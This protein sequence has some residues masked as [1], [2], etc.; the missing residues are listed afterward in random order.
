MKSFRLCVGNSGRTS[1]IMEVLLIRMIGAKSRTGS[2]CSFLNRL[3][4]AARVELVVIRIVWPSGA[5]RAASAVPMTPIAPGRFS[6]TNG[7]P[8]ES[9][10]W[11]PV[12]RA[13]WW[14]GVPGGGGADN[15]TGG[16]G[17]DWAEPGRAVARAAV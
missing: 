16:L 11:G 4:A 17:G 10:N 5:A 9:G 14:G 13:I 7:W 2:Y 15:L 6:F 12:R 3:S 8:G 1:R